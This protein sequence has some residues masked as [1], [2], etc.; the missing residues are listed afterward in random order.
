MKQSTM[1]AYAEVDIILNLMDKKYTREI[2]V[3]LREMFKEKRAKDYQKVI[4]ED[5]P[6]EEQ[7]LNRETLAIL[8][9]LNYNYWCKD[10]KRKQE[11]LKLYSENEIKHQKEI[12]EKYNPD[13]IFKNKRKEEVTNEIPENKMQLI[14]YKKQKWYRKIFDKILIIFRKNS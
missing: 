12:R 6:L 4:V 5:K 10:E 1:E 7:N 14:E 13:N 2:P 8:A 3:K 9:V 11:L